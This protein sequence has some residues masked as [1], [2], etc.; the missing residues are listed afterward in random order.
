MEKDIYIL[1]GIKRRRLGRKHSNRRK[2]SNQFRGN[3]WQGE[4]D[5]GLRG[6]AKHRG[7]SLNKIKIVSSGRREPEITE[8]W[9]DGTP[10]WDW[11]GQ[12]PRQ[13]GQD[14]GAISSGQCCH[15]CAP[16]VPPVGALSRPLGRV[17]GPAVFG[18]DSLV[19]GQNVCLPCRV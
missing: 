19:F 5:L 18:A 16:P 15:I 17:L 8:A 11:A 7:W 12:S 2:D 1:N 3:Y 6:L 4:S 13:G 14:G 10:G 9:Q